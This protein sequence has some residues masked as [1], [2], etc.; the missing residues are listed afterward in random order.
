MGDPIVNF[1]EN[2]IYGCGISLKKDEFDTYCNDPSSMKSL[3]LFENLAF[4]T[5]F[6]QFGNA[7]IYNPNDWDNVKT[8]STYDKLGTKIASNS[9]EGS[10]TLY[11]GVTYKIYYS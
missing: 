11:S 8:D 4:W 5:K 6:G 1:G 3:P 9:Q 7:N 10:C 2:I